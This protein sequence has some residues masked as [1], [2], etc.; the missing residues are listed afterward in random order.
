MMGKHQPKHLWLSP[1]FLAH[2]LFHTISSLRTSYLTMLTIWLMVVP[3]TMESSTK[4]TFL[5]WGRGGTGVKC[6]TRA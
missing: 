2:H 6:V 3:L 4:R 1:L 5:P